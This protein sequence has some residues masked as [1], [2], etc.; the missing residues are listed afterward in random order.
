MKLTKKSGEDA[1]NDAIEKH[2]SKEQI[3]ENSKSLAAVLLN[4][5]D[6]TNPPV[7]PGDNHL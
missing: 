4:S 2:R 5:T 3:A 6:K 1:G 7:L